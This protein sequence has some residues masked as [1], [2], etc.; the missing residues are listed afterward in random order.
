MLKKTTV[1]FFISMLF[2]SCEKDPIYSVP[3]RIQPYIDLFIAEAAIRGVD[4]E[5]ED[6]VVLFEE[7]L[8]VDDVQAA[9]L[10][11]RSRKD[12]PTIK[13]DT[14][15]VNWSSN[16]SSREQLVFHELGHCVLNRSHLDAKMANGNY[17]S[18]MRPS[19]E[20][21]YGPVLSQFKR[22]HY[23][24]ELFDENVAD[25]PW[26]QNVL[27]YDDILPGS[28]TL[29]FEEDFSDNDYG[30]NTGT[31]DKTKRSITSGEYKLQVIIPDNYYVG[32][33]LV[34]DDSRDFELEMDVRITGTGF[35][36]VLWGGAM[37]M[38]ANPTFHT[39]F[40]DD[41]VISIGTL[42]D[43]T[44][45]SYVYEL[46]EQG[47]YSTVTIRRIGGV[48]LYYVDGVGIDNMDFPGLNGDE[49]GISFGGAAGVTVYCDNLSL[50]YLD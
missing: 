26:S 49:F 42:E 25:A 45:S 1:L 38:G 40:F 8:E 7:D 37:V 24:G 48:Y 10:C 15:T 47:E 6:L 31:S 13:L 2:F 50:Y 18:S 5:I 14:T 17:R 29:E 12:P 11:T 41:D 34:I 21:I 16:L 19:G 33:E 46:F 36:G 20:Q 23:L 22:D 39:I 3:D 35:A 32:N 4:L 28:K 27:A 43:G 9:G 44:E 30:W